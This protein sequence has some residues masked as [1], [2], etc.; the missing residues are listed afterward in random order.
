M[1]RIARGI[2]RRLTP[3]EAQRGYVFLTRDRKLG[4]VLD[5]DCFELDFCGRLFA[6]RRI[7]KFGRFQVPRA[8]VQGVPSDA[9]V[10][11]EI[12]NRG[13]IRVEVVA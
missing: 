3:Y 5:K 6:D 1:K 4:E 8:V 13:L 12:V 9:V 11:I 7:D 2:K 10:A